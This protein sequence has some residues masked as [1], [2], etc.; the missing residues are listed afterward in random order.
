MCKI[1]LSKRSAFPFIPPFPENLKILRMWIYKRKGIAGEKSNTMILYFSKKCTY[2]DSDLVLSGHKL[3]TKLK[4]W[5]KN[6]TRSIPLHQGVNEWL[7]TELWRSVPGSYF[8]PW[9][10]YKIKEYRERKRER[11]R[12]G[13]ERG[14]EERYFRQTEERNSEIDRQGGIEGEWGRENYIPLVIYFSRERERVSSYIYIY[15]SQ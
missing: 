10:V 15:F 7:S 5:S 6:R 1:R 12:E 14:K 13:R 11:E 4:S 8:D 9:S 3:E 2:R